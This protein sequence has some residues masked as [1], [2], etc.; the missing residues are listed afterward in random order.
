MTVRRD[1]IGNADQHRGPVEP[2]L[3]IIEPGLVHAGT[4]QQHLGADG[5]HQEREKPGKDIGN[6]NDEPVAAI[7]FLGADSARVRDRDAAIG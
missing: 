4:A 1:G 2:P 5:E 7:L 3:E 6:E